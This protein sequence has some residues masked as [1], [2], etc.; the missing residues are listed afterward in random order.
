MKTH[1]HKMGRL[2]EKEKKRRK[3]KRSNRKTRMQTYI[4]KNEE[5]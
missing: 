1:K 4:H 5:K 3:K 2:N